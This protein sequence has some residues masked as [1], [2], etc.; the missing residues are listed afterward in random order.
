MTRAVFFILLLFTLIWAVPVF[1]ESLDQT[2]S[3][4]D[5]IQ[6]RIEAA[7]QELSEK[8]RTQ[9]RLEEDVEAVE[10]EMKALERRKKSLKRQLREGEAAIEESEAEALWA[11]QALDKVRGRFEARLVALYKAGPAGPVQL[12]F[13]GLS[14]SN[15]EE[16]FI[17]MNRVLQDDDALMKDYQNKSRNLSRTL[18]RRKSLQS[19]RSALLDEIDQGRTEHGRALQL[20]EKLLAR[21]RAE[22][23]A[24]SAQ[25]A[26]LKRN[27]EALQGLVKRLESTPTPQ[28]TA[29]NSRFPDQKGRLPWPLQAPVKV[30]FGTHP[31]PRLGIAT[32]SNGFEFS[33]QSDLSV[34]AVWGGRVV[35]ADY[36]KGYGK[37]LIVDHGDSYFSLYAR[38][39][40][41]NKKLGDPVERGEVLARAGKGAPEGLYFELRFHGK[42]LDPDQWLAPR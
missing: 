1:G 41:L 15:M 32:E 26:E 23:K 6:K 25:L 42:P 10:S 18:E 7:G 34:R 5:A 24:L 2:R 33:A 40:S 28:Y 37:L 36:F 12:L 4:L 8:T 27:A 20:K 13:S 22:K 35:F 31:N 29:P 11:R 17:Y 19:R 3:R 14:P 39:L 9:Q 30:R 21:V 38:A 16:Q